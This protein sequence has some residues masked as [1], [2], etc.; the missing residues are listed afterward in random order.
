[1]RRTTAAGIQRLICVNPSK[2]NTVL[3][4]SVLPDMRD[5]VLVLVN[6][7]EYGGS[8]GAVAV[9][10]THRDVVEIV[11]HEI[12]SQLRAVGGRVWRPAAAPV[13][14]V[15][16]TC[17]SPTPPA[18]PTGVSSSGSAWIDPEHAHPDDRCQWRACRDSTRE[19][20]LRHRVVPSHLRLENAQPVQA[21]R[22]DQQRAA[23]Q[24]RV[25][26]G[27]PDRFG[28]AGRSFDPDRQRR[29]VRRFACNSSSRSP[30]RSK[31]CGA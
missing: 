20:V 4:S 28:V 18:R 23:R 1:M 19:P 7:P 26:L 3:A 27:R 21:V 6:D 22:A 15:S 11:L 16:G 31:P 5:I 25:Q 9:A 14:C 17:G 29:H 12:G 13:Q 24:T 8:G 30:I 2:V 10:S